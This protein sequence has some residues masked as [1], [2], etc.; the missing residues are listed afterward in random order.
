MNRRVCRDSRS[1]IQNPA[2]ELYV[3]IGVLFITVIK[4]N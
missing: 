1:L 4:Q 2:T 3:G